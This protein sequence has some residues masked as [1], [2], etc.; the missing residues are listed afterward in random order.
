MLDAL[1]WF[2]GPWFTVLCVLV[3]QSY[4]V[5]LQVTSVASRLAGLPH[6]CL[7][8]YLLYPH[9]PLQ[10]GVRSLHSVL[11]KVNFWVQNF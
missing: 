5:N 1:C 8:S 10:P 6:V 11:E 9:L 4:E 2:A 3:C 7:H